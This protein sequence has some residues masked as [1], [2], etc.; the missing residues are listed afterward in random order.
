MAFLLASV[1]GAFT[2]AVYQLQRVNRL[3]SIDGELQDRVTALTKAVREV[4]REG[5]PPGVRGPHEF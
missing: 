1:L 5:P 2:V 4:Y 3:R